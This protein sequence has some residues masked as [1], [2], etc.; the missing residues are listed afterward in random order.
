MPNFKYSAKSN[1][2]K[3]FTGMME[4]ASPAEVVGE[5]RKKN[6][7]I[8][9]IREVSGRSRPGGTLLSRSKGRAGRPKRDELVVMTRQ[10]STMISAGLTLLDSLEVL[11]EQADSPRFRAT[12]RAVTDDIRGGSDLSRALA[13]HPG[14]FSNIYVNMVRAGEVSGQLDEILERLADYLESSARLRREVKSALTYPVISLLMVVGIT[15]FLMVG[16]VPQ[17]RPIFDALEIEMP[18]LTLTVLAAS[19]WMT[20]YWYVVGAGVVGLFL[21]FAVFRRTRTGGYLIDATVLRLP[22]FGTLLQKV[23]LSRFSRTFATLIRSGVPILG[24]LDVVAETGGNQVIRRAVLAA[25]DSVRNGNSISGPLS[26]SPVFPPMVTKMIGIGERS[27]SL[28]QLLQKVSS[29]YDEQVSSQVKSLTSMIEPILIGLMGL[30]VGTIVMAVF[31]PIFEI[32]KKLAAGS[33]GG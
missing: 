11:A 27:G 6:L 14:A 29:F 2:G 13:R 12:L 4:A 26:E 24:A 22:V 25:R 33:G 3:T 16:I 30:F 5:L 18:G 15:I 19:D 9:N 32:Q 28:E 31:L 20:R 8:L 17:F 23:A 7:T 1:E 10:L 21:L